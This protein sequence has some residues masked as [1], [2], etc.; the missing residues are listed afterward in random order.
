MDVRQQGRYLD[1]MGIQRW[2]QRGSEGQQAAM[3]EPAG[4]AAAVDAP[5]PMPKDWAELEVAVAACHR[6]DLGNSRNRTVFGVGDRSADWMI[7]GEAPGADEDAQGEP[8]VGPAGQLLTEMLLAIG[9]RR[10]DVFITNILKCR[11]PNNRNPRADEAACCREYLER[12]IALVQPSLIIAVGGIAAHNLL[13]TD[14]PVGK[15]RGRVHHYG[16]SRI[17]LVVTYHPS[18]LLRSPLEKRKVWTDLQ[19]ARQAGIATG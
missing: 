16:E 19:F 8:F 7:I 3:A 2:V 1:A 9:R 13:A 18:Y 17:P 5:A 11:P 15:L 14:M 4:L 6:C 10:Q 12:Q